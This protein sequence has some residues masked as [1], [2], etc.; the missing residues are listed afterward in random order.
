MAGF[1]DNASVAL[2]VLFHSVYGLRPVEAD[3]AERLRDKG[4]SV[5]TPDLYAGHVAETIDAGFALADRVGWQTI[6]SRARTAVDELAA[7]AILA[8]I[9]MGAS[10]VEALLPQRPQAAGVLLWHGLADIPTTARAGLPV[11]AH[12]ADP[13]QYF[14]AARITAWIQAAAAGPAHA[15]LFTYPQAGHFFTDSSLSDYD[16]P[17]AALAWERSVNFLKQL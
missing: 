12:L 17:A 8:G 13:D 3:A 9:S 4:H 11:Q 7:D 5:V 16:A 6:T 2:I 14:P 10:V 1:W 15:D